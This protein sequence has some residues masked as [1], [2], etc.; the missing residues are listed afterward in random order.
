VT[1]RLIDVDGRIGAFC[2]LGSEAIVEM[3][4]FA[5]YHFV[6]IDTE[7][8]PTSER[9]SSLV[10]LV[11]AAASVG[12]PALVR[13]W[14]GTA[15]VIGGCLDAGAAGVVVPHAVDADEVRRWLHAATMPPRGSRGAAPV[16]RAA[17]YGFT[18]PAAYVRAARTPALVIPLIEDP[19]G[20][21]RIEEIVSVDGLRAVWFGPF[22]LGVAMGMADPTASSHEVATARGRVYD[23]CRRAGV[24]VCD[25][26]WSADEADELLA[27]G[28][29]LVSLSNDV[30]IVGRG[31]RSTLAR[32]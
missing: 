8:A 16:V 10:A 29:A 11:R 19:D 24:A 23:A 9:S 15:E 32:S 25:Y 22:D 31:L 4:G 14:T 12:M 7:H 5:G 1:A 13:A 2:L 21:D 20:V 30:S 26:A 28:A 3:M 6:I 27:R 18:D 17:R